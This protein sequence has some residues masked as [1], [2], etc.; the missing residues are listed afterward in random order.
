MIE[1]YKWGEI[2][3][4]FYNAKLI[5]GNGASIAI[6][7]R[8]SYSSLLE[9]AKHN[10]LLSDD[11]NLLFK[12]FETNDF[13]LV[14]RLVW[15]AAKV[16]KSFKIEDNK[17]Y[18]AYVNLRNALI[19]AVQSIHPSYEE[20]QPH[21]PQIL[22]FIRHFRFIY[23]LNYDLILYWAIMYGNDNDDMYSFK[24]CFIDG[25]FEGNWR[26][27][28]NDYN[29]KASRLVF[30][31]H[32][33]LLLGQNIV[34]KEHKI[35]KYGMSSLLERILDVWESEDV[36]PLFVSEGTSK[37]KVNAIN[38]SNY[39]NTIYREA[40]GAFDNRIVIYGWGIGDQDLHIL[41]ALKNYYLGRFKFGVSVY[42]NDQIFCNR[43]NELLNREFPGC[44]VF[45]FNSESSGCW[46]NPVFE[47]MEL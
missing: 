9:Y 14:L 35:L 19:K 8:F 47:K 5:L 29:G 39:L 37:Q 40:L 10:N 41:R 32:G 44:T 38:H 22:D 28:C 3:G 42:G 33:S 20:V 25:D 21:L 26:Y 17:T 12:Y 23:T 1:I 45:F 34:E 6:D 11:I 46:N 7:L 13:E 4:H 2:Q 15:Q 43:V 31:P 36:I 27:L 24:D 18:N 30:Y 16:N